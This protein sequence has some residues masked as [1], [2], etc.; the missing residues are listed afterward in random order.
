VDDEKRLGRHGEFELRVAE[1]LR[2]NSIPFTAQACVGGVQ[3][4]FLIGT[5]DGRSIV[6]DAKS[7]PATESNIERA[8][9]Q[10][11]LYQDGI[12]ADGAVVVFKGL[13]RGRPAEGVVGEQGLVDLLS[14]MVQQ[15][16]T[17]RKGDLTRD[18][19]S[20]TVTG[21]YGRPSIFGRVPRRNESKPRLVPSEVA[22]TRAVF[23]AMPFS[24]EYDD[25][26][27]VAMAHAADSVGAVCRRVD[28]ED[29][30]GDIVGEIEELIRQSV[31]IIADLSESKPNVLYETGFAHALG[32]PTVH[33]CSTPLDQLPFD[34]RNWNTIEYLKGQTWP[35]RDVLA[36]RLAGALKDAPAANQT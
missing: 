34:V 8:I 27:F 11:Q 5:P 17:S 29:F 2:K 22:S 23:A 12:G 20:E 16:G 6:V 3:P 24:G 26:Y 28:H 15:R 19:S 18:L 4:D 9:H 30:E 7:C 35:L 32:R 36:R 25:T 33:I 14:A 21:F 13:E 31:A 1:I 10:V